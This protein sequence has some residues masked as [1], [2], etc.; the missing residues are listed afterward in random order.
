MVHFLNT[1]IAQP[2][3]ATS[4]ISIS[5]EVKISPAPIT[6]HSPTVINIIDMRYR[7]QNIVYAV[8]NVLMVC[9]VSVIQSPASVGCADISR[10]Y[11]GT[12]HSD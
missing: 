8:Q 12:S 1:A 3:Y 2:T 7:A 11:I 6:M 4:N 9:I 10:A 5:V